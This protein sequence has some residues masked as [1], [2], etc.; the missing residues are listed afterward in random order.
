MAID[1]DRI[2]HRSHQRLGVQIAQRGVASTGNGQVL[3]TQRLERGNAAGHCG[4]ECLGRGVGSDRKRQTRS[5]QPG[6]TVQVQAA[7]RLEFEVALG[8]SVGEHRRQRGL[9]AFGLLGSG[10][11][12][13]QCIG[14]HSSESAGT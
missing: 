1:V 5:L 13:Q 3:H 6:R 7:T 2:G 12:D 14:I 11:D 9:Q 4:F 10:A 8:H